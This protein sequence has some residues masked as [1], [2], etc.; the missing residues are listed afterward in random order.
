MNIY[1]ALLF[2]GLYGVVF[3]TL[4]QNQLITM[5]PFELN[6]DHVI[7]KVH[8]N[9]SEP[10]NFLFDSGAGGTLIAKS[11]ADS[12]GLSSS[13]LRTNTGA[14]GTHKVGLVRGTDIRIGEATINNVTVMRD[15]Q[16]MEEL[17]NGEIVAG[18]I[19][20]HVLSRF[21]VHINYDNRHMYIYNRGNFKYDGT[22]V[23]M[24]IVLNYNI[25][26]VEASLSISG[27]KPIEGRFLIDTGARSNLLISSPTVDKYNLPDHIGDHYVLRTQ[28]GSS[29]KKVKIMYGRLPSL[30]FAGQRF[31][32][33]PVVLSS[34]TSGVLSFSDIDGIIGNRILQR[35]NLTFDYQ[36]NMMYL[37]PGLNIRTGYQVNSSGFSIYFKKGQ[38]FVKDVVDKSPARKAGLKEDDQIISLNGVLVEKLARQEIRNL[39]FRPGTMVKMVVMRGNKLKYTEV[40]LVELI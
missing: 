18:I 28:V 35:F 8:I 31:D 13:L 4:G 40:E 34:T 24:P 9:D 36:R 1:K 6:H 37:E 15:Q 26:T 12:L 11:V 22:G 2:F 32:D 23:A 25:P 19:G 33:I 38:P 3:Q 27:R 29:H 10:L 5:V 16:D 20:F 39:F 21:V 7:V 30:E 14:A 17:D